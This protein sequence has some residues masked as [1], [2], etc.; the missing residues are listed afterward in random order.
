MCSVITPMRS[1]LPR[2]GGESPAGFAPG[3]AEFPLGPLHH[4]FPCASAL[5]SVSVPSC[6]R[7][8]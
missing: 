6:S 4:L 5:A 2:C 8:R 3:F 7:P 1:R